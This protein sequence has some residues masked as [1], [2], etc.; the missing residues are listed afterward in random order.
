[1]NMERFRGQ[2]GG[3]AVVPENAV[4]FLGVHVCEPAGL[5]QFSVPNAFHYFLIF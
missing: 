3:F 4:I 1:M 2:E 5:W